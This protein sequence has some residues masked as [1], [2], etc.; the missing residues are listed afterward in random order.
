M[1]MTTNSDRQVFEAFLLDNPELVQLETCLD[2]FN[3]YMTEPRNS[4]LL[5]ASPLVRAAFCSLVSALVM[6]PLPLK[7]LW[8]QS[9]AGQIMKLAVGSPNVF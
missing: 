2:E 6:K 1:N 5:V 4:T 3:Y 7:R 9:R 8:L